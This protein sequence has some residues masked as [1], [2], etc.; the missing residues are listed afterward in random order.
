MD[1][2]LA[3]CVAAFCMIQLVGRPGWLLWP[4]WLRERST[5][6]GFTAADQQVVAKSLFVGS[7]GM[8]DGIKY[9]VQKLQLEV[10]GAE[11]ANAVPWIYYSYDFVRYSRQKR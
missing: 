6:E 5:R 1:T 9:L 2:R 7:R 4:S 8:I 3:R 11:K 10:I